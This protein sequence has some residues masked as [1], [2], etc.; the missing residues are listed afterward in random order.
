MRFIYDEQI[1]SQ[2]AA[3]EA[4]LRRPVPAL[5]PSR[6]LIFA[7]LGTSLHAARVAAAWAGPL[8]AVAL[9][10]HELALRLPIPREAQVVVVT[11]GGKGPF[12][13][14]VLAKARAARARTV[15]VVGE[16]A[17]A[18]EADEI[19]RTCPAE[20]AETHT[21]SYLTALA[22]LGR[23]LGIDLSAAPQLL[24]EALALPSPVDDARA[25]ASCDRLLVTGFGLDAI[26]ASEGALKL[27][28]STF[29]WAEGLAVEQALHGP[30]AALRAG[31]GAIVIP[32]A[33][34][35]RGRTAALAKLCLERRVTSVEPQFPACDEPLRPLIVAVPLQRLAAEIARLTGGD[36][37]HSRL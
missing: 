12:A 25:L 21:V 11:H 9:D 30:H 13:A 6:P 10:A 8:R 20:R 16:H 1:E 26:T 3:V 34:D 31:M 7:G 15:A 22:V 35:D 29:Q 24:S 32:P 2:P 23:M 28:E 27:K 19:V 18:L 4:V 5:D 36:P 33:G 17:P 14:A 37:D